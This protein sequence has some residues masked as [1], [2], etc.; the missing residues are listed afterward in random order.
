M[1]FLAC[2]VQATSSRFGGTDL[3]MSEVTA[4]DM[5]RQ[6]TAEEWSKVYE[7]SKDKSLYSNLINS[8]FP[9]IHGNDEVKRGVLLQLFSGVAKTTMESTYEF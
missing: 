9:S 8:L 3:P 1:A 5:K 7:M 2:S 6:M 4:D